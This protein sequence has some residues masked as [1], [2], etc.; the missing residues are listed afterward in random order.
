ML[1]FYTLHKTYKNKRQLEY[2]Y[3]NLLTKTCSNPNMCRLISY[4]SK[5]IY[6]FILLYIAVLKLWPC[7]GTASENR[8]CISWELKP[9][10]PTHRV[11]AELPMLTVTIMYKELS[12]IYTKLYSGC[13]KH[14]A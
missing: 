1:C 3:C 12:K 5:N 14:N 4:L 13:Q 10:P 2:V 8:Q 11:A 9:A 6:F 7:W